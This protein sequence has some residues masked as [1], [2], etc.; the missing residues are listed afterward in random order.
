MPAKSKEP[1]ANTNQKSDDP[2][3]NL[4]NAAFDAADAVDRFSK[5][6]KT[7][8][9][10]PPPPPSAITASEASKVP[11]FDLQDVPKAM[12]KLGMPMAAKLQE[13]W[14]AGSANYSN[15]ADDLKNEINQDGASYAPTM[16]DMTTV[17]MEWVLSF[18]RAKAAFDD[19][20]QTRV[21]TLPALNALKEILSCHRS[22]HDIIGWN[23]AKSNFLE[24]HRGFQFQFVKVNATWGQRLSE[25]LTRAVT[26][27]G[28]PDD[29]TGA[30][31]AFDLYAAVGHAYFEGSSSSRI[32]V[33]TEIIVYVRDSYDFLND[34]YLG[35][36]SSSH[37][38]VVPAHQLAEGSGYF[39]DPVVEG[40]PYH[41]GDVMYPVTNKDYREWRKKHGRG[42]D[43]IIYT[44]RIDVKL[45]PPIRVAL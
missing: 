44:D 15:D 28:V 31:G 21:R 13:R 23:F 2:Y 26:A 1:V 34:Q 29:L 30:L 42:G 8:P 16:V 38:A 40:S 20:V 25:F 18:R 45:S 5:W 35:H 17:K 4:L 22:R 19:L 41:K 32:A 33:V 9:P 36:W 43:F 10:P 27:Q 14:F 12:L 6:L 3:L 24:F 37:V 7:P 39:S 11:P